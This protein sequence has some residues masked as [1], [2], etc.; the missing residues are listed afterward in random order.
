VLRPFRVFEPESVEDACA[1]LAEAGSDAAVYAGG[2]ELLLAMKEN[3]LAPEYLV[4]V[5]RIGLGGVSTD[6][7]T[8]ELRLG[9]T[10]THREIETWAESN[11]DPWQALA[12]VERGVANVRVRNQGT[13]GGNLCFGE[14]HADPGTLLC[15]WDATVELADATRRR[16]LGIESFLLDEFSTALE[17]NEVMTAI[18]VPPRPLR[19]GS[20]Y[21]RFGF[22]ERPTLGV[23]ALV[24]LEEDGETVAEARI[25]VGAVGPRPER[26][27]AAELALVGVEVGGASWA[28]AAGL[29]AAETSETCTVSD[30]P[31]V[32]EEYKRHLVAV[33]VRRALEAGKA[34]VPGRH[35]EAA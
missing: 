9:A 28:R 4:D 27:E 32:S 24:A 5:K 20:A 13:I 26:A 3:L 21:V 25:A 16:R 18:L 29:A 17:E 23:A 14:P 35:R 11:G 30:E 12:E 34:R 33:H 31:H 8:G 1:F 10:A 6:A 7:A 22:L 2:T 19:S 15:A